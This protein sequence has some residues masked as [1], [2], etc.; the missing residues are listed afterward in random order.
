M[1]VFGLEENGSWTQLGGRLHTAT[2][3]TEMFD[4]AWKT[5]YLTIGQGEQVWKRPEVGR[6]FILLPTG[7]LEQ[8]LWKSRVKGADDD[9]SRYNEEFG[10]ISQTSWDILKAKMTAN[11]ARR[12]AEYTRNG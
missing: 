12:D 3:L 6:A 4:I 11:A 8:R 5:E 9:W 10:G 7:A 2:T 1:K